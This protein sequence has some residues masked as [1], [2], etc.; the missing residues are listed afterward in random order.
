MSNLKGVTRSDKSQERY[1]PILQL[2]RAFQVIVV[3]LWS[4]NLLFQV[5]P[6]VLYQQN[7]TKPSSG[8]IKVGEQLNLQH[9]V[10]RERTREKKFSCKL[11]GDQTEVKKS[12]YFTWSDTQLH[13][14]ITQCLLDV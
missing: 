1:H 6:T 4:A 5:K 13:M 10:A 7:G 14:N 3:V 8:W 12:E 2:Y 9:L 11:A